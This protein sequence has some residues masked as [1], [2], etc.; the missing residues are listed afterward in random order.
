MT[1]IIHLY[2]TVCVFV[3]FVVSV[4]HKPEI[5]EFAGNIINLGIITTPSRKLLTSKPD[6]T[7]GQTIMI[8]YG[9]RSIFLPSA[10]CLGLE[11]F[12]SSPKKVDFLS[13]IGITS[14]RRV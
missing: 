5:S 1:E 8:F 7:I 2:R 11:N 13:Y 9:Q 4:S 10:R 14:Q 3:F 12:F 6:T